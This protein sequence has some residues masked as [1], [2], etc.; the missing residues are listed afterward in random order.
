MRT[1]IHLRHGEREPTGVHLTEAGFRRAAE[2]GRT[3]PRFDRVVTSPKLR[4]VETAE[5]MGYRVDATLA[6]LG[7]LPGPLARWVEREAPRSFADY[8]A[9]VGKV[10]EASE[11]AERLA[12]LWAD[13][14]ER[15]PADRTLLL[16]S[17]GE[18]I[19]LGT[20]G[21]LGDRAGRWGPT[22]GLLEGVELV[23]DRTRWSHGR[24][25]RR[26]R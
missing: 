8:V 1:L 12:G 10:A 20:V 22:L 23:R 6:E 7:G 15:L 26:G 11:H 5:A 19:E 9:L 17:H 13:E 2:L 3:L 25:L 14:L 24:V 18:V 16:V 21:A 4:A